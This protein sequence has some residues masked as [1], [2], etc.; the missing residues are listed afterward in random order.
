MDR[1]PTGHRLI[2]AASLIMAAVRAQPDP[3]AVIRR[4]VSGLAGIQDYSVMV[5]LRAD[6][7]NLRMPEK[8]LQ[9]FFQ[10]P[11]RTAIRGRG[12][13]IVPKTGLMPAQLLTDTSP[14]HFLREERDSLATYYVLL[15]DNIPDLPPDAAIEVWINRERWTVDQIRTNFHQMGSTQLLFSYVK[16]DGFW[17][18]LNVLFTLNM[19]R[20]IPF[21]ERPR[22]GMMLGSVDHNRRLT[23]DQLQG[24][25]TLSFRD[26][27]IN[28]GLD[29]HIFDKE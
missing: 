7:P 13:A 6:I 28:Q 11:N 29:P 15:P 2:I 18:P 19:T 27:R 22:M 10:Q 8:Q 9:F 21:T 24:R 25:V 3:N 1:M 20:G 12:F 26:Y 14:W 23:G 4:V 16:V 5:T 17:V